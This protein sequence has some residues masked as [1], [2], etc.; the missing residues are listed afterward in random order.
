MQT[1]FAQGHFCSVQFA[2]PSVMKSLQDHHKKWLFRIGVAVGITGLAVLIYKRFGSYGGKK[3]SSAA[4]LDDQSTATGTPNLN[5]DS[6]CPS[7][8]KTTTSLT[9]EKVLQVFRAQ[10]RRTYRNILQLSRY[11]QATQA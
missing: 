5:T 10:K 8:R 7:P 4:S 11:A 3:P 1:F 2:G 6:T 9:K